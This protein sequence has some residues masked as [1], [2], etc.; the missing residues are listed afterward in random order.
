MNF[1][2]LS[3]EKRLLNQFLFKISD[4]RIPKNRIYFRKKKA[5]ISEIIT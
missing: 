5:S 3:K 1:Q 4:L 2:Y